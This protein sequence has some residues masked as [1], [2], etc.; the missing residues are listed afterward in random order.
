MS[1]LQEHQCETFKEVIACRLQKGFEHYREKGMLKET[2]NT[3]CDTV[4]VYS[5]IRSCLTCTYIHVACLLLV[6]M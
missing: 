2:C 5:H 6:L 3:Q 1:V 4:C